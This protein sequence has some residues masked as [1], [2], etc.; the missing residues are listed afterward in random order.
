MAD[1]VSPFRKWQSTIPVD[2]VLIQPAIPGALGVYHHDRA[3]VAG[4]Q[5]A[6]AGGQDVSGAVVQSSGL[7]TLSQVG[8]YL[9]RAGSGAAGPLA[10]QHVVG[11]RRYDGPVGVGRPC[12]AAGGGDGGP[13]LH[14]EADGLR[15]GIYQIAGVVEWPSEDNPR[16]SGELLQPAAGQEA[17][18][19]PGGGFQ[20]QENRGE[21]R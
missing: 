3:Q 20:G 4:V 14:S 8:A 2:G 1:T 21:P 16:R 5:A 11:V 18:P 19:V 6:G 7:Q 13:G 17:E 12:P 15:G 9:S 10:K